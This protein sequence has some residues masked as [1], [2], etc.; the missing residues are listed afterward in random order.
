MPLLPQAVAGT[1]VAIAVGLSSRLQPPAHGAPPPHGAVIPV[2]VHENEFAA[3]AAA[4]AAGAKPGGASDPT[5]A[6]TVAGPV[7]GHAGTAAVISS[8]LRDPAFMAL[9]V[10]YGLIV[11]R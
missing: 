11:V 6:A 2:V 4:A 1:L 3:V 10:A 5:K 9:V 8:L 7:G